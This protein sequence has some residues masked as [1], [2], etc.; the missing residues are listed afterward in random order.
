MRGE[1]G[2]TVTLTI[3]RGDAQFDVTLERAQIPLPTVVHRSIDE[4][5]GYIRIVRFNANTTR[6][7]ERAVEALHSR[8]QAR[9]EGFILDLRDNPG[10]LLSQALSVSDRFL[11]R[12]EIVSTRGRTTPST[13]RYFAKKGDVLNGAPLVLLV[14]A[15]S[16]SAAEIV[17]GA[18]QDHRRGLVVGVRSFGKGSVQRIF[19]VRSR[20]GAGLKL[21]VQKYFTPS[22]TSIQG[23][24]IIPDVI[25]AQARP[26]PQAAPDQEDGAAAQEDGAQ[27]EEDLDN[28]LPNASPEE[29]SDE[30]SEGDVE[31]EAEAA[32][33]ADEFFLS[34][35]DIIGRDKQL[36]RALEL[37]RATALLKK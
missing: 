37:L 36:E 22:G 21:T 12:G 1:V 32:E 9:Y 34:T 25:V 27:R 5:I 15:G 23:E 16:A 4:T 20:E 7:V 14:N 11:D 19:E 13:R 8:P 10:G 18:L 30:A 33:A 2:T 29:A 6:D 31:D 26:Q 17:A 28:A 35:S 3:L 24:G